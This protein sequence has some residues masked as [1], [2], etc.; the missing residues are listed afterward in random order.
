MPNCDTWW[1]IWK[2]SYHNFLA[3]GNWDY[4][5]ILLQLTQ[6]SPMCVPMFMDRYLKQKERKSS[7]ICIHFIFYS[8][9]DTHEQHTFSGFIPFV[10]VNT[11]IRFEYLLNDGILFVERK[12]QKYNQRNLV[13][14]VHIGFITSSFFFKNV[15]LIWCMYINQGG[16]VTEFSESGTN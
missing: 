6:Y 14:L 9:L 3:Y 13:L 10:C 8:I 1:F 12:G 11:Q 5:S 2:M 16:L 15:L 4:F 7:L